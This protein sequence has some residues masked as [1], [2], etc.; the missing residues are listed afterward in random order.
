MD[1][2]TEPVNSH[3]G[4]KS[5]GNNPN[6]RLWTPIKIGKVF[7]KHR[8]FLAPLTR[9]RSIGQIPCDE[10]ST[11]YSQRATD[12]G[13]LISEATFISE[14]ASGYPNAPGIYS[15]QQV[16][17]WKRIT[18]AVHKKGG[19]IYCQL[20]NIGITNRGEMPNVPIIGPGNV[21]TAKNTV[22]PMTTEQIQQHLHDYRLA[23][24]KAMEAGFDGVE[25]HGAHGYLLEQFLHPSLNNCRKDQYSSETLENRSRFMMEAVQ[26]V[27]DVVGQE[28]TAI[29]LSPFYSMNLNDYDPFETFGYVCKQLKMKFPMMSYIS[30]TEPRWRS[31]RVKEFSNDYFR[32]IIRGVDVN[33]VSKTVS[34]TPFMFPEPDGINPTVVISA[35]GYSASDAEQVSET[36]GDMIGFGRIFISNP[37]LVHRL[38]NGL[39]LNP[40]DRSTFYTQDPIA[41]YIDYPFSDENTC[42]FVPIGDLEPNEAARRLS[43]ALE[44]QRKK[45]E[46]I[47]IRSELEKTML[48]VQIT[49]LSKSRL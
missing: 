16:K 18:D 2:L 45:T 12:G 1:E 22:E 14:V 29:R 4:C 27:V 26:A 15:E 20:W 8:L 30:L 28:K 46:D 43:K 11:Y 21:D 34:D 42:K 6:S 7:L 13:L 37:D 48:R 9:M 10:A 39:E 36:T 3:Q 47:I 38:R 31:N 23:A 24:E 17:Q 19:I 35:G 5:Y 40:Y 25:V 44:A 33:L 32:A 41:G 49:K